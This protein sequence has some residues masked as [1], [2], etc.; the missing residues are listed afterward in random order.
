MSNYGY[1]VDRLDP[2]GDPT[3]AWMNDENVE[4]FQMDIPLP[5]TESVNPHLTPIE[6]KGRVTVQG[7]V[8][9]QPSDSHF[10]DMAIPCNYVEILK[11]SEQPVQRWL[12]VTEKWI[13]LPKG[14]LEEASLLIIENLG[15]PYPMTQQSK[16][17]MEDR[18][19]AIVEV[20]LYS[21]DLDKGHNCTYLPITHISPQRNCR[22][23]PVDVSLIRLR[24]LEGSTKV[25]INLL[26]M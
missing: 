6:E 9:F 18:E 5:S 15:P 11:T 10:G 23:K 26:P 2:K 17:Q 1:G 13:E 19:K 22:W 14:W 12:T 4:S 24:C 8:Y 25:L 3:V 21:P 7:M 20:A 16:E